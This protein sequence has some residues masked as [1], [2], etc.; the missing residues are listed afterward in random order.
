MAHFLA[1][2]NTYQ[3]I[4][5]VLFDAQKSLD[6]L[7]ISKF[8]AN[9]ELINSINTLLERNNLTLNQLDFIAANQGPGPF[10][11]LRVV[12]AT[13]NGISFATGKPLVGVDGLAAFLAENYRSEF[14]LTV[15]LLNAFN[16][17]VYYGIQQSD[18]LL[19]TG[20]SNVYIFLQ[21]LHTKFPEQPIRF[22]GNAVELYRTAIITTFNEFAIIEAH[23][24]EL[25]STAFIGLTG[26]AH[27][28]N[29]QN[30]SRKLQPLYLKQFSAVMK[31]P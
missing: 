30:V 24:P 3:A 1:L 12:I 29:N 19:S 7:E 21:E 2:Q 28:H 20:S 8:D 17:D 9:K 16:N 10:T 14:P 13:I 31:I 23:I 18:A 6:T 27:W 25:I 11:T 5:V 4:E 22:I 26:L 15:A